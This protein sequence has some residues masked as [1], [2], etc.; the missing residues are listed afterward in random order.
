MDFSL[1][2]IAIICPYFGTFPNNIELTFRSMA[3]NNWIDWLIFTDNENY[4][5]VYDN[6]FIISYTFANMQELVMSKIGTTL[7]YPY[8]ICDYKPTFGFLFEEYLKEYDFWGYCDLDV[9]FGNLKIVLSDNNLNQYDKI[10]DQGHLSIYRNIKEINMAFMG[11]ASVPVNY[12]RIL[13]SIAIEVFDETYDA[14]HR[15]INGILED[16]GF[17][18]Y[19]NR[20]LYAD[21]N[22]LRKN[23]YPLCLPEFNFYYLKYD[24]GNLYVKKLNQESFSYEVAYAHYQQK[25]NLPIYCNDYNCYC[26]VPKGFF[27]CDLV[28]D[29][30]FYHGL[31]YRP[32]LNFKIVTKRR[33]LK[34]KELVRL[35]KQIVFK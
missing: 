35:T 25:K 13:N 3:K 33:I 10:L 20:G 6:I 22:K 30:C 26:S 4:V 16:M 19:L 5:G 12:K 2:K 31:D 24:H 7:L 14:N 17:S 18:V 28:D 23:F 11:S 21:L 34:I 29:D 1:N 9:I 32:L 15:G 8:K 27:N